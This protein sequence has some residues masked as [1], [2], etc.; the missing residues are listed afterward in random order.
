MLAASYNGVSSTERAFAHNPSSFWS[1][2]KERNKLSSDFSP[3]KAGDSY[4]KEKR[5]AGQL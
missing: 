1:P 2:R 5:R 4:I 3:S